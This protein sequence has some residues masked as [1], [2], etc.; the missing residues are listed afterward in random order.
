MSFKSNNAV[1]A[2]VPVDKEPIKAI[3]HRPIK[4]MLL[5]NITTYGSESPW[6]PSPTDMVKSIIKMVFNDQG[7]GF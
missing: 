4:L 3:T 7:I 2:E 5:R 6:R 1:C